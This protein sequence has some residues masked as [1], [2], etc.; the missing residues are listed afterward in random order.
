MR[1]SRSRRAE[2]FGIVFDLHAERF[3]HVM[4]AAALAFDAGTRLP[5]CGNQVCHAALATTK[6]RGRR[7]VD[8]RVTVTAGADDIEERAAGHVHDAHAPF[9][10]RPSCADDL[11]RRLAFGSQ[12]REERG[13]AH[14]QRSSS[15]HDSA[16]HPCGIVGRP[17]PC[18]PE[19][20][21]T[22]PDIR[23]SDSRFA[24][25]RLCASSPPAGV[26]ID[27]GWNCTPQIGS[28]RC[29]TPWITPSS[30]A[31]RDGPQR[32]GKLLSCE[33]HSE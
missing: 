5:C 27:S 3:E 31:R 19:P 29:A 30:L 14:G 18:R 4:A 28:V 15:V 25:E 12:R 1:D 10:H 9:A 13:R 11:R 6:G 32:R 26:R 7:D 21:A 17:D 20:S 22:A 24:K 2:I 23:S 8:R 16:D 33:M